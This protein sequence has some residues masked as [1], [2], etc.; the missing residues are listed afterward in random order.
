MKKIFGILL[1]FV[2]VGAY[3]QNPVTAK[4]GPFNGYALRVTYNNAPPT[5]YVDYSIDSDGQM[6][7]SGT[8]GDPAIIFDFDSVSFVGTGGM[9]IHRG[10]TA[11]RITATTGMIRYNTTTDRFEVNDG[12]WKDLLID[13]DIGTTVQSWDADLD[14]YSGITPSA[15]V[16]TLLGSSDYETFRTNLE[17]GALA[18]LSTVDLT[19]D[20]TGNLPVSNLNSG[21]SASSSTYWRGDGTWATPAGGVG[22]VTAASSFGTNNSLIVS[23]GTGKGVKSA[24]TALTW[25]G[26]TLTATSTAVVNTIKSTLA[27]A[28]S[29][30]LIQ[31]S[32]NEDLFL[33]TYGSTAVGTLLGVPLASKTRVSADVPM[34]IF[35]SSVDDILFGT[36]GTLS[37]TIDG[38]TQEWTFEEDA[39]FNGDVTAATFN[40]APLSG[41]G[42]VSKVGTPVD[43]QIAVW[44]GDGTVEGTTSITYDAGLFSV[45]DNGGSYAGMVAD[46]TGGTTGFSEI[47][48]AGGNGQLIMHS[49]GNTAAGSQLGLTKAGRNYLFSS[50]SANGLVIGTDN[51][52]DINVVTNNTLSATIDG[53]TQHWNY[54]DHNLTTTGDI[55]ASTFNGSPL[56]GGDVTKV[57]TPVD[58]QIGLWTGDGTIE[59]VSGLIW[60]GITL[61]ATSSGNAFF[62]LR[63]LAATNYSKIY[64]SS[65]GG[66]GASIE[67]NGTADQFRIDRDCSYLGNDLL[68]VGT[69]GATGTR[70]TQAYFTNI[71]S[72][73]AV[74]VDS[75]EK[76][77]KNITPLIGVL[78]KILKVNPVTYKWK[79]STKG[80]EKHYGVIAQEIMKI[81]PDLVVDSGENLAVRYGELVP[82]LIKAI[83]ELNE[84]VEKL[85]KRKNNSRR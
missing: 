36:N 74:T 16:Q 49:Y 54:V 65:A 37:A 41:G 29:I 52:T 40:G 28:S 44:T 43:N 62:N 25:N 31:N 1:L 57:G 2:S 84:K 21:T 39:T 68:S 78:D 24:G 4:Q 17:L 48:A 50:L 67:Y 56:S 38:T 15:N 60:N 81:Y 76:L 45:A 71:T 32:T 35:T 73:N 19:S 5:V 46:V 69:I 80:T 53:T 23:D 66:T 34:L 59:G 51:T 58:N 42:N 26:T 18:L 30:I 75:D 61:Q 64:M 20:I 83:Q 85:S 6:T 55:T 22:D 3:G 82:I 27:S 11:Q 9:V 72:T 12:D 79:D 77:K 70:V 47:I 7:I 63:P 13:S 33:G 10:T 8:G 14:T